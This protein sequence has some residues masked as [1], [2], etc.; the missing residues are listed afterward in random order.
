M[1]AI[2]MRCGEQVRRRLAM[3]R[4]SLKDVDFNPVS[5]ALKPRRSRIFDAHRTPHERIPPSAP[6][7]AQGRTIDK[8]MGDPLT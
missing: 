8:A 1:S 6:S 3:A 2:A 4:Q 7:A 5:R